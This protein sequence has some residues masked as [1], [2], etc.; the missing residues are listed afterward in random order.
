MS[1]VRR[2]EPLLRAVLPP[3]S[4]VSPGACD[5]HS[6]NCARH[7]PLQSGKVIDLAVLDHPARAVLVEKRVSARDQGGLGAGVFA[8]SER[9]EKMMNEALREFVRRVVMDP[10][11]AAQI[12]A[13][14]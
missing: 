3:P 12:G 9:L 7:F 8:S 10:D 5:S 1:E 14:Q 6:L 13:A 2:E 11:Q 4:G